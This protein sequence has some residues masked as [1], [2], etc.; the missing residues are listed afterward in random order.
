MKGVLGLGKESTQYYLSQIHEKYNNEN[1]DF[2][3]CPML[4]YQIDF[5]EINPFL[6]D[7]FAILKERLEN[8]LKEIKN[9]G[10]TKLLIPNIT[11]HETLDQLKFDI[12]ISHPVNLTIDHLI[13]QGIDRITI[14]GTS[15]TMNSSYLKNKFLDKNISVSVVD[16]EDQNRIDR[17]RKD[18]YRNE[19]TEEDKRHLHQLIK[20]YSVKSYVLLACTELSVVASKEDL[21]FIDMADLQIN[22]FLRPV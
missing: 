15:Y 12:E 18:V 3:T 11:L 10:I 2:S 5:Q 8:Y 6:P 16:F 21:S 13:E 9:L 7:Q 22:D 1:S 20:K 14:F 17:F 19:Q 4:V